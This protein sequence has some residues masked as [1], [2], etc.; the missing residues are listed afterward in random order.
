M[1]SRSRVSGV[2]RSWLM[3]ASISVRLSTKRRMRDCMRIVGDGGLARLGRAF[4]FHRADIAPAAEGVG[5]FGQPSDGAH[6]VLHEQRRHQEQQQRRAHHPDDEQVQR[7]AEQPLARG[8]HMQHAVGQLH[9]DDH[10]ARVGLPVGVEGQAHAFAHRIVQVFLERQQRQG[11][12]AVAG[13]AQHRAGFE[14]QRQVEPPGG[15]AEHPAAILGARIARQQFD[16]HRDVAGHATRQAA[17]NDIEMAAVEQEQRDDLQRHERHQDD[18][19]R[20][21][22]QAA[23]DEVAEDAGRGHGEVRPGEEHLPRIPLRFLSIGD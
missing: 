5:G 21:P 2:R 12:L 22:E 3:P 13:R 20:P 9:A 4:G 8:L 19:Q 18:Q 10:A 16:H 14:G 1:P 6:L 23:R 17:R 15:L 7:A 11:G